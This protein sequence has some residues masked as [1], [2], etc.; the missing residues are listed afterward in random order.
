MIIDEIS[1]VSLTMLNTI[2]QQCNKIRAVQQD[3]AAILGAM[4]IVVFMGDFHQFPPIQAQP[5]WQTPNGPRAALGQ[6]IWHQFKNVIILDEQ[7]QQ[8]D[9]LEFQNLLHQARAGTMTA[10][11][12]TT[13]NGQVTQSLYLGNGLDSVCVSRANQH[14]HHIN[15]LQIRHFTEARAQDIYVF[16]AAHSHTKRVQGN[17]K[18]DNLLGTQD[19]EGTAKGPGLFLYTRGMPVTILYNICT[20][21]GL[22]NGA[23]GI[24]AGIVLDPNSKPL[25]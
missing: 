11:D 20:A 17:L 6:L 1:M 18:I 15:Q 3:S 8:R 22:V 13:L 7:M 2:N 9:D 4:P 16:P 24:A 5:L 14:H 10:A 21:L 19:G 25:I 12:V 23:K